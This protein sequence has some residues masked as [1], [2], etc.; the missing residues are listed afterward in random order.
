MVNVQL[1]KQQNKIREATEL[2]QRTTGV[3]LDP[4]TAELMLVYAWRAQNAL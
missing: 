2:F 3:I 4:D 1:Q